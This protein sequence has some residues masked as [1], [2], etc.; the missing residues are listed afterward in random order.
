[1]RGP[2]LDVI[3]NSIV[4]LIAFTSIMYKSFVLQGTRIGR[5]VY[6]VTGGDFI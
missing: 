4:Y 6:Q 5:F 1:M 2:I 3:I